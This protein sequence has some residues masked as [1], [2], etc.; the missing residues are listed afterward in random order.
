[1]AAVHW[2]TNLLHVSQLFIAYGLQIISALVTFIQS[3]LRINLQ[4]V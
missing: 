3:N 2:R 4:H 1:M